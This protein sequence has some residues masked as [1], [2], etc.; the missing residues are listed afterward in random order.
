MRSAMGTKFGLP[1]SVVALTNETIAA[2]AGPSFQ[3]GSGSA[4][5]IACALQ[6]STAMASARNGLLTVPNIAL[7]TPVAPSTSAP[8]LRV[9]STALICDCN[10]EATLGKARDALECS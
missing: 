5:A 7:F 6:Q 8:R 9:R 3:D 2:L 1:A 10:Q 4:W